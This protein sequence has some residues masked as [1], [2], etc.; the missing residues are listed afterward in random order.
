MNE[1]KLSETMLQ[2]NHF[3][4]IMLKS[5]TG[6][7]FF[8]LNDILFFEADDKYAQLSLYNSDKKIA[9][10]HSLK[11]IETK[12]NCGNYLGPLIFFRTHRQYIAALHRAQSWGE[13]NVILLENDFEIPVGRV[14]RKGIVEKLMAGY[15]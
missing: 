2:N 11:D 4:K 12:L 7:R 3:Y 15:S 5:A 6:H 8:S 9:V 13:N 14:Y 1:P 10:F